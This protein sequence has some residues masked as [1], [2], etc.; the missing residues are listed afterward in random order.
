MP[1]GHG[2]PAGS[3]LIKL[4]GEAL[5]GPEGKGVD[6]SAFQYIAAEIVKARAVGGVF[7]VVVG[8]GNLLRG[9][10]TLSWTTN[11]AAADQVGMLA[12]MMNGLLL[13]DC[14]RDQGVGAPVFGALP[15]DGVIPVFSPAQAQSDLAEGRVPILVGGTGNPFFTTDT[16]A[17]LR[18]LELGL[19]TVIKATRVNGVFESDPEQNP[20]ARRYD[21]LSFDE[22]IARSLAVVD[23]TAL[24]LCRD[25]GLR[26]R[27]LDL[28]IE[29]NLANAMSD[30]SIGTLLENEG[31]H[32]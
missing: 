25:H 20:S 27:V 21:R 10:S 6:D 23:M 8:G 30:I 4:S 2:S 3:C 5:G 26:L 11:R 24:T 13:S 28:G 18:A 31:D 14:L 16:T 32:Q 1:A 17:C 12:T 22:A 29:E 15:L 9:A 19:D 7:A